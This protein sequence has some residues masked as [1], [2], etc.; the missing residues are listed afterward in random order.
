MISTTKNQWRNSY[1]IYFFSRGSL[2]EAVKSEV[3]SDS[4]VNDFPTEDEAWE[5]LNQLNGLNPLLQ[6]TVV[7]V[8]VFVG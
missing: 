1:Q 5:C 2:F 7:K 8:R 6:F 4:I 3:I